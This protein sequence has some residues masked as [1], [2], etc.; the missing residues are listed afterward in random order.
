MAGNPALI[1]RV[2][3][4]VEELKKNLA[5]GKA[6]IESTTAAVQKLGGVRIEPAAAGMQRLGDATMATKPTVDRLHDSLTKFDGL[7][8][9]MGFNINADTRAMTEIGEA[10]GK[11]VGQLGLV[12]TAGLAVGVGM[13]AWNLGRA[14]AEFF[15]LDTKVA[16]A[17]AS[18]LGWGSVAG[19][20]AGAQADVLAHASK[21]AGVEIQDL[22]LAM[23]INAEAAKKQA[24]AWNTSEHRIAGWRAE[25]AKVKNDGN[26][27]LLTKDLASQNFEVKELA[28]RYHVSADAVQFLVRELKK[29]DDAIQES[30]KRKLSALQIELTTAQQRREHEG[31][32]VLETTKLWEDY[33][34]LRVEHGGTANEKAIADIRKWMA[35]TEAAAVKGGYATKA[36]YAG[37]AADSKEM[38]AGVG[39]DW[40]LFKSKSIPALQET[41]DNA[42]R[43]YTLMVASGK[44]HRDEL[45]KQLAKYHELQDAARGYGKDSVEAQ[46]AARKA[47]LAHT[48]ALEQ[49]K[50]AQ[51][52]AAAKAANRAMGGT[53]DVSHA[54]RDPEIMELLHQGW[55]LENAAQIV[56]ARRWHFTPKLYSPK[57]E[58]E[59]SPDPSERVP[60]YAGG[61]RNAP[62][63]WARVGERGP[64][65]MY[66]PSGA[67][68]Y[69][70]GSG[71]STG[72]TALHLTVNVTQPLGTPDAIARVVG[73]AIM[74]SLRNQGVRFGAGLGF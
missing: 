24:E 63:G 60:G 72:V 35:E 22:G 69:P 17:T 8:A 4:T 51:E 67:D 66:V 21:L 46:E 6:S 36:F 45:D 50:R 70:S 16:N 73:Q 27:S 64:E 5:E 55:S 62:G 43:T 74:T 15:D 32:A 49:Q 71:A 39:I 44:F 1:V 58:L 9:A 61:V 68:I 23:A 28:E 54:A 65:T 7:L 41:A 34:A 30:N 2:A 42:L 18:L 53:L 57:G 12:A 37:L 20:Q 11:T 38:V 25:L 26:L 33:Y 13:A 59:S 56:L 29:A 47:T 14:A 3:A 48:E 52:E 10:S 19:E 40:D 31:K